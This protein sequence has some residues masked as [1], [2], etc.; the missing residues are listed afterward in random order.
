MQPQ[1]NYKI[2]VLMPAYNA[3]K[4]I[5]EA[6]RSVLDQ[7]FTDFELLIVNDGSIDETE[8]IIR[9][10][11]DSRITLFNQ[12][13]QGIA[14]ALNNGLAIAKA[15]YIARFDADDICYPTRLE[16]QYAFITTHPGYCVVGCDAGYYDRNDEYVFTYEAPGHS[17]EEIR[18]L[19]KNKCPF[20]HSGV[21]YSKAAIINAGGYNIHAHA[22]EDHLLWLKVLEQGK[23]YNLPKVLLKVRLTPFSFTINEKGMGNRYFAIKKNAIN[24]AAINETEGN[25]LLGIIKK[26][27]IAKIREGSYYALLGKKYLWN[28]Y[29]PGKARLNLKKALVINPVN[30]KNF[31]LLSLSYM[32][33]KFIRKLYNRFGTAK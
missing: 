20:I 8:M 28:N 9:S 31:T 5:G 13:N 4:Y 2:T 19:P 7:T 6:I 3:A 15:A 32:P 22:F 33:E 23:V 29:Q 16:E 26:H 17:D 14:V 10:F 11:S 25:R 24:R 1:P 18:R 21:L 27:N 30:F 12:T